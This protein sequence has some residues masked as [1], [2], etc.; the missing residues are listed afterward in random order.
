MIC[1]M[2]F[3]LLNVDLG[4][5]LIMFYSEVM[6]CFGLDKLDLCNLMELVD[7]VDLLKDVDFKVFFGLVNDLKG[8][9]VVLCI[10]G[11]VV[12]ICK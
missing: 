6:C 2:W 4:D 5:F 10:L 1:E 3:E 7:V 8:C 11:G 12:L 9:V